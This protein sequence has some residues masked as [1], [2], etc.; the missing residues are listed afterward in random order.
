M[1]QM[2]LENRGRAVGLVNSG[3]PKQKI[4]VFCIFIILYFFIHFFMHIQIYAQN[5]FAHFSCTMHV[6]L[7]DTT[8][9]TSNYGRRIWQPEVLPTLLNARNDES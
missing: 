7:T 6:C 4:P 5:N 9:L 3:T 1:P 2:G 8:R